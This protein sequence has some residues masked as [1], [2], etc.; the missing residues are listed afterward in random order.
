MPH[1]HKDSSTKHVI[2]RHHTRITQ[3]HP[4]D[5]IRHSYVFNRNSIIFSTNVSLLSTVTQSGVFVQLD[6]REDK[7][8][9][10]LQDGRNKV[11]W[12]S[13]HLGGFNLILKKRIKKSVQDCQFNP[14]SRYFRVCCQCGNVVFHALDV[15]KIQVC[16]PD[17]SPRVLHRLWVGYTLAQESL[18]SRQ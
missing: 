6:S 15:Q 11:P 3:C 7:L 17:R 4:S 18:V 5:L 16:N 13:F 14:H 10:Q 1:C 12:G 9:L 8:V 2:I